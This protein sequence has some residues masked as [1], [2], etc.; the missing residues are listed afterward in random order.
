MTTKKSNT[1]TSKFKEFA[2]NTR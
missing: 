2:V 1:Y